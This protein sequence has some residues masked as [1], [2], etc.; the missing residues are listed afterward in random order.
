MVKHELA[1]QLLKSRL[2]DNNSCIRSWS[3][4]ALSKYKNGVLGRL[5]TESSELNKS[6]KLLKIDR[7]GKS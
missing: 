2:D 1:I 7:D 6:L 5:K 3:S 4:G